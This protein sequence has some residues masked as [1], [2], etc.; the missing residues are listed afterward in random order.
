MKK[1]YTIPTPT[2]QVSLKAIYPTGNLQSTSLK[3]LALEGEETFLIFN[4]VSLATLSFHL[5]T[6]N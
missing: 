6:V 1:I 4:R 3:E 2:E 5:F